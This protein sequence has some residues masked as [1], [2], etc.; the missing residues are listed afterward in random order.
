MPICES[1]NKPRSERWKRVNLGKSET[2]EKLWERKKK[3]ITSAIQRHYL[4]ILYYRAL[5]LF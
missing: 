5:D 2:Y 3:L 4:N 1:D